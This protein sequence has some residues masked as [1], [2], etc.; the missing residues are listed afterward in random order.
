MIKYRDQHVPPAELESILIQYPGVADAAVV[1]VVAEDT[2][3]PRA[4][5]AL[6]PGVEGGSDLAQKIS[7]Y[8]DEKVH[9]YKRLR[10]GV[11]FVPEIP[12]LIVGKISRDKLPQLAK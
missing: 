4:L 7:A 10:G 3:V 5:V 12:R 6:R 11:A 8:V 1:G 2:D 9:D